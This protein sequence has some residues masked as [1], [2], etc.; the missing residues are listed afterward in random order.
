MTKI[1]L[2]ITLIGCLSFQADTS[3]IR[4]NVYIKIN[5]YERNGE[6]KASAMPE[7]KPNSRLNNYKRRFE[8]LLINVSNIHL[9]A[10]AQER[11]DIWNL[12]PDTN[13]LKRIYLN[14]Y[15]EDKKLVHYFEATAAPIQNPNFEIS[16][17]FDATELME[18][19][20]KFFYCDKV[21]PDTSVQAH[22][23]I[24]LNGTSE[25]SWN[26]DYTL[27]EAFCFEGIFN[28]FDNEDSKVWESFGLEKQAACSQY[29]KDIITL[30]QYLDSVKLNLFERMKNNK[31]LKEELLRYYELNKSNLAFRIKN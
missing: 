3:I 30:D 18:V 27:L 16:K 21:N 15:V 10:Q 22:V 6:I 4:D 9:P 23:C 1:I 29:D 31:D 11:K 13:E 25:A 17:S 20:S 28:D 8:Y 24:G 19:A 26:K 12:Y 2:F 5:T 7:L 14:K